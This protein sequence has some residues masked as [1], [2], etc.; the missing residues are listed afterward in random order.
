M[1]YH[2]VTSEERRLIYEWRQ[3]GKGF[4]EIARLLSRSPSTVSSEV[5]RNSGQRGYRPK[6]AQERAEARARRP[7]PRR[8]TE[9]VRVDAEEKLR[10]G[11]TPEMICGRARLE[12]RESVCKETIYKH[13]YGDAKSGGTLWECL[14][15]NVSGAA[16]GRTDV[17]AAGSLIGVGSS[18]ALRK[19]SYELRLGTGRAISWSV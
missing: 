3:A 19:W 11:W 6:Q 17:D 10:K 15:R 13:V 2:R 18:Y 8:F 1:A 4:R 5:A 14:P 7:G 16:L 12:G 9:E